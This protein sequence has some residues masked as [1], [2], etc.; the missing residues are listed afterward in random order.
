M[1]TI[2]FQRTNEYHNRYR[3][4]KLF[5]DGQQIGLISNG[6]KKSFSIAPGNHTIIAK[7]DWCSSHEMKL[8]FNKNSI[9][10]LRLGSYDSCSLLAIYYT[11]L[12]RKKYLK[13]TEL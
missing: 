12:G 5:V 6:E 1:A 3:D 2:E 11:T 9:K 13:L 8:N 10:T 7:I 4:I